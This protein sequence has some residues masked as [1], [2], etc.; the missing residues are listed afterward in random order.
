MSFVSLTHTCTGL[1]P[2]LLL[3]RSPPR[4]LTAAAWSGLEPA[5]GSRLRRVYL[6]LS[7]SL[8][9]KLQSMMDLLFSVR[10]RR[11]LYGP[12]LPDHV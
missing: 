1:S 11:T 10:L 4:L 9:T 12:M 8:C 7:C 5:S 2:T 6:H 3:Q